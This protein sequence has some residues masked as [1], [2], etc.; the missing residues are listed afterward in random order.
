MFRP[1]APSGAN[2]SSQENILIACILYRCRN[3]CFSCFATH[4]AKGAFVF[5]ILLLLYRQEILKCSIIC[6]EFTWW[7]W[8]VFIFM[9]IAFQFYSLIS[10]NFIFSLRLCWFCLTYSAS[11][12]SANINIRIKEIYVDYFL[13]KEICALLFTKNHMHSYTISK[14][15]I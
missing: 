11:E 4:T 3:C 7:S 12:N 13:T 9:N 10:S 6:I 15:L 5:L 14:F 8:T 2:A 1:L